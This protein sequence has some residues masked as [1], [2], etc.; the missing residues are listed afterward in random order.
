MKAII[1]AGG[2]GTRIS[3]ETA[4]RPKPMIEIGGRPILWHIMKMYSAHGIHDFV[5][6]CGYKGY[7][8]KEVGVDS[9]VPT[10][11]GTTPF[12]LAVW[13]E[14]L[15]VCDWLLDQGV[16]V[17]QV[18]GAAPPLTPHL[19]AIAQTPSLARPTVRATLEWSCISTVLLHQHLFPTCPV[20]IS[21]F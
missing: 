12:Q 14:Q 7:V 18:A 2:L 9:D 13:Q 19:T 15:H 8:I 16:D 21:C 11:D 10:H 5:V 4:L 20:P 17:H 3:E 6:C 1:L